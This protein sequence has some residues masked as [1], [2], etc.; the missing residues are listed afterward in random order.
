MQSGYKSFSYP[1]YYPY[2]VQ[3]HYF[4]FPKLKKWLGRKTFHCNDDII[5]QTIA[6]YEDHDKYYSEEINKIGET[7][8]EVYV[9]QERLRWEII[10]FL[11]Q[12]ICCIQKITDLLTY[13]RCLWIFIFMNHSSV[14]MMNYFLFCTRKGLRLID[15]LFKFTMFIMYPT[16]YKN[17]SP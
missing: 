5:T 13:P 16:K 4:F 3:S 10:T 8:V 1:Q 2:L 15:Q 6:Y 7:S 12:K 14:Q 17:V 9:A 11:Y